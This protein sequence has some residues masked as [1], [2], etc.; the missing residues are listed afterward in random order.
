MP[1]ASDKGQPAQLASS[2][3]LAS[4]FNPKCLDG[5]GRLSIDRG[6]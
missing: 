5:Q 6:E 4:D 2:V 3:L 1:A